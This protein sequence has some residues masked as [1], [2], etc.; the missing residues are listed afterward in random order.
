MAKT[1]EQRV[2][3]LET[4]VR[5]IKD[6]VKECCSGDGPGPGRP[7]RSGR[8]VIVSGYELASVSHAVKLLKKAG[9]PQGRSRK[10]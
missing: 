3:A 9:L 2:T 1:L 8:A 10:K 7:C 5:D 6:A 4:A